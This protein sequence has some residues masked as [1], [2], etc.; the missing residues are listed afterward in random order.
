MVELTWSSKE[1]L[2][3]VNLIPVSYSVDLKDVL[4]LCFL[5][6][7]YDFKHCLATGSE[8]RQGSREKLKTR[9]PAATGVVFA[10]QFC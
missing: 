9:R 2:T 7:S 10:L 6:R 3:I 4:F 5:I 1:R 8:N